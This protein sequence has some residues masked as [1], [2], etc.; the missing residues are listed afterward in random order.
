MPILD[1]TEEGKLST[2]N[3]LEVF[4]WIADTP[5][6]IIE[7]RNAETFSDDYTYQGNVTIDNLDLF[8]YDFLSKIVKIMNVSLIKHN[9]LEKPKHVPPKAVL[10]SLLLT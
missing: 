9:I 4:E 1:I 2:N 8:V 10:S 6:L 3:R 7:I 5:S